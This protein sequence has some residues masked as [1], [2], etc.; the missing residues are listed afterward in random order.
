VGWRQ[1]SDALSCHGSVFTLVP[2]CNTLIYFILVP[3]NFVQC[4]ERFAVY[5][6]CSI[7]LNYI[8]TPLHVPGCKL[9]DTA[10][11]AILQ[12]PFPTLIKLGPCTISVE[13]YAQRMGNQGISCFRVSCQRVG[14]TRRPPLSCFFAL[15]L[16]DLGD[17]TSWNSSRCGEQHSAYDLVHRLG[18]IP[19]F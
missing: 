15:V 7:P 8:A 19:Q 14:L 16:S 11:V 2:H 13:R 12:E 10:K 3:Y 9:S 17:C 6:T 18:L 4:G 5:H 1:L